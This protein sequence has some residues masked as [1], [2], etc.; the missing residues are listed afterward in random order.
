M[1]VSRVTR[2]VP[3]LALLLSFHAASTAQIGVTPRGP[4]TPQ[5]MP[6][7][8]LAPTIRR[9]LSSLP[10]PD[11]RELDF[12]HFFGNVERT[13]CV[14]AD[15]RIV[16]IHDPRVFD[17]ESL[18]ITLVGV[19]SAT[20]LPEDVRGGHAGFFA[21][22][23]SGLKVMPG[24]A[25]WLFL[26]PAFVLGGAWVEAE[27]LQIFEEG[28]VDTILGLS[29][30]RLAILS[31][32]DDG[33]GGWTPA[34]PV[35][36]GETIE[37]LLAL[38]FDSDPGTELAVLTFSGV[39]V[40]EL[41]GTEIAFFSSEGT[42]VGA[43]EAVADG[44]K[45]LLAWATL[46]GALEPI[47]RVQGMSGAE[48]PLALSFPIVEGQPDEP[49]VL[50]EMT[51]GDCNADGLDDLVL[52]DFASHR[53]VLLVN[54]GIPAAHFAAN[55][56]GS[57]H[58]LLHLALPAAE[59]GTENDCQPLIDDIDGDDQGDVAFGLDTTDEV[60]IFTNIPPPSVPVVQAAQI[61][62]PLVSAT[63]YFNA[64]NCQ[65]PDTSPSCTEGELNLAFNLTQ[66]LVDDFDYVQVAVWHQPAEYAPLEPLSVSHTLHPFYGSPP[67][68]PH[69]WIKVSIPE[70]WVVWPEP[71][72]EGYFVRYRF[73]RANVNLQPPRILGASPSFFSAF[74]MRHTGSHGDPLYLW[75]FDYLAS[76]S[77]NQVGFLLLES[78]F[79][80]SSGTS[81]TAFGPRHARLAPRSA[82]LLGNNFVGALYTKVVP[83]QTNQGLEVV[84]LVLING[85]QSPW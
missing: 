58:F 10:D 28:G 8:T 2:L 3:T 41:D 5:P 75:E 73:V 67:R 53:A 54:Q 60:V 51:G 46:D 85:A 25:S 44:G 21:A 24:A 13:L 79:P 72:T 16:E 43:I 4:I 62:D 71:D 49:L 12:G 34:L 81:S 77:L 70:I 35:G 47:L 11:I 9:P 23:G 19:S 29:S 52:S 15:D 69:Q 18:E 63:T 45:E 33:A 55:D 80:N 20:A 56:V 40:I 68:D 14:L 82:L 42:S 38:D 1:P 65:P 32:V 64:A 17:I 37:D 31:L 78:P 36:F 76:L 74:T 39:S 66:E 26:A 50:A 83:P 84:P 7:G 48:V 30:D 22:D 6:R 61:N 57:D 27:Q 59:P